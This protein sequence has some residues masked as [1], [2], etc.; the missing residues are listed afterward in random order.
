MLILFAALFTVTWLRAQVTS[1][2]NTDFGILYPDASWPVAYCAPHILWDNRV[3]SPVDG[4]ITD[5]DSVWR[6]SNK[7]ER[8][9]I[10]TLTTYDST[11]AT[12]ISDSLGG[13]GITLGQATF[14]VRSFEGDRALGSVTKV[15]DMPRGE[16][17]YNLTLVPGCSI[18][19]DH[20]R[21]LVIGETVYI[22]LM[23]HQLILGKGNA[24]AIWSL[25]STDSLT[26]LAN[27]SLAIKSTDTTYTSAIPGQYGFITLF[28]TAYGATVDTVPCFGIEYQ[29]KTVSGSWAGPIDYYNY[30]AFPLIDSL[31]VKHGETKAYWPTTTPADSIRFMLINK[32]TTGRSVVNK[33]KALWRD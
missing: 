12:T 33:L 9:W 5:A 31:A 16:H 13:A 15:I 26:I 29:V 19:F 11:K 18:M 1:A 8:H 22:Y 21:D 2:E 23:T 3:G 6:Y 27:D 32:S 14:Q 30:T 17:I 20:G 10:I 7:K 28:L 4:M 24:L 25:P